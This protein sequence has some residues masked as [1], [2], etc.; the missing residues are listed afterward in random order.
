MYSPPNIHSA[1]SVEDCYSEDD[2]D[3]VLSRRIEAAL[4]SSGFIVRDGEGTFI[5][6]GC[7]CGEREQSGVGG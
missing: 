4:E 2:C 5:R 6:R 1:L 7:V 3:L